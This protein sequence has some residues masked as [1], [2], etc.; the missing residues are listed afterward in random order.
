M[1]GIKKAV[2][3]AAA[4]SGGPKRFFR[5][6]EKIGERDNLSSSRKCIRLAHNS[7][8]GT[9]EWPHDPDGATTLFRVRGMWDMYKSIP[10]TF[11]NS[12][13]M[14]T[15]ADF[16]IVLN[17]TQ[18]FKKVVQYANYRHWRFWPAFDFVFPSE[19]L[20]QGRNEFIIRNRTRPFRVLPSATMTIP[21]ELS[22]NTVYQISDVQVLALS[23]SRLA[24]SKPLPSGVHIGHLVG[25]HEGTYI[26]DEDYSH[27][28]D[29]S[30]R[31]D[32][33]NLFAFVLNS[34]YCEIN[35]DAINVEAIK[36]AGLRVAIRNHF[37]YDGHSH[38]E[39]TEAQ[40]NMMLRRFIKRLGKHFVGFG[41]SERWGVMKKVVAEGGTTDLSAI[42]KEF[43][44]Q[45]RTL[46]KQHRQVSRKGD[47]WVADPSFYH[48]YYM[49][50]GADFPGIEVMSSNVSLTAAS[51]RGTAKAFGKEGW[52][53]QNAW[54]CQCYGGLG[55]MAQHEKYDPAFNRSRKNLLWLTQHFLYLSGARLIY[56]E[57][58]LF[59]HRVT[60]ERE[61][62]D[63]RQVELRMVQR[64]FN[65]F[66][67]HYPLQAQPITDIA[68]LHGQYDI[69]RIPPNPPFTGVAGFSH[70]SLKM[71]E[72]CYPEYDVNGLGDNVRHMTPPNHP[73]RDTFSDT[74]FGAADIVPVEAESA[75]LSQYS[76]LILAG[77]N[78]MDDENF[79]R[80][81]AYV[82]KGGVLT[83]LLPHL[84]SSTHAKDPCKSVRTKWLRALCGVDF[85]AGHEDTVDAPL[86]AL[87]LA[88]ES[89][90]EY[91]TAASLIRRQPRDV[92][93]RAHGT[94]GAALRNL[95][96]ITVNARTVLEETYSEFPFLIERRLGKGHVFLFNLADYPKSPTIYEIIN[97]TLRDIAARVPAQVRLV[98]GQGISY[99]VYPEPRSTDLTVYAV[100][101]DWFGAR[102]TCRA[103]FEIRGRRVP[104]LLHR[105]QVKV[106]SL[107]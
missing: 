88:K 89:R 98:S 73:R 76:L 101:N 64:E 34:H 40:Y 26:S 82:K 67:R 65:D 21:C 27:L 69:S 12:V 35:L 32:Q 24:R 52:G 5:G 100:M 96:N 2:I 9:F 48:R 46:L 14:K 87:K 77:W 17:G 84:T 38:H 4:M 78:T 103:I 62:D 44:R 43:R 83:L 29:L 90:R 3:L 61:F 93:Y 56:A 47:L 75:T 11:M 94:Y 105:N 85:A 102:K 16:E 15:W 23:E 63:P 49:M 51:A 55:T 19:C 50:E 68:Y 107:G 33:G 42:V 66:V 57:S 39:L 59:Q 60:V 28:I 58:G 18:I 6:H 1:Y 41:P 72:V 91:P 22:Q 74:P 31:E 54:E 92:R 97:A 10:I 7:V 53:A 30:V 81:V 20:K 86:N 8:R 36:R 37:N 13:D 45:F 71:L 79:N 106:I 95:R 70:L 25:G 80:L 104:V 99:S